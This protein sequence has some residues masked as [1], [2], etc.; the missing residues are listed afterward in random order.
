MTGTPI[1]DIKPYLAYTDAHPS[2]RGGFTAGQ[3]HSGAE[4]L[5]VLIPEEVIAALGRQK[6]EALTSVLAAD[7]RPRY[8]HDANRIYG[9]VFAGHEVKFTVKDKE[10]CVVA[11][12]KA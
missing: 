12:V 4:E 11:C 7:P 3:A 2:A 10:V 9:F 8:Q 5:N 1:Y 6:A